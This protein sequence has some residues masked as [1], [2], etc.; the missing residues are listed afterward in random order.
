MTNREKSIA[1]FLEKGVSHQIIEHS[2]EVFI[3]TDTAVERNVLLS[4]VVKTLIFYDKKK[5]IHVFMVPGDQSLNQRKARHAMK[6]NKMKFVDKAVLEQEFGLIIGAISPILMIGKA[7]LF[8]DAKLA[9]QEV[10]TISTGN[11]GSGIKLSREDLVRV[12]KCE[13]VDIT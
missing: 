1:F 12:L 7:R 9:V 3:C 6:S 4:Q 11:P 8:M 13:I 2:K 10:L 5:Q